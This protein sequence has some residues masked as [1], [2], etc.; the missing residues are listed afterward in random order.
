M[1]KQRGSKPLTGED[2]YRAQKAEITKRNEAART[3]IAGERAAG[4]ERKARA[5]SAQVKLEA[6]E[7]P[8][9]PTR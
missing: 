9:P 3:R 7:M 1:T 4:D 5:R 2:A 6:S 8:E